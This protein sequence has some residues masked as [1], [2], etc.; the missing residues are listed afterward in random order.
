MRLR[1][2]AWAR[3]VDEVRPKPS[4]DHRITAVPRASRA[5]LR[6]AWNAT[7]GSSAHACTP[8]SPS[9]RSGSSSS[10]AKAGRGASAA[11]RRSVS[12]NRRS[13]IEGPKPAVMVSRAG[14]SPTASP[15]SARGRRGVAGDAVDARTGR[16]LVMS[17]RRDCPLRRSSSMSARR[18]VVR[19]KARKRA[20]PGRASTMPAWWAPSNGKVA[21]PVAAT[22]TVPAPS[23]PRRRLVP[24]EPAEGRRTG[25][26]GRR[27]R[28]R[29]R[30]I[31]GR[32][33]GSGPS[34]VSVIGSGSPSPGDEL[35][36]DLR[37]RLGQ[38]VHRLGQGLDL[39]GG[40]VRPG[41]PSP[42]AVHVKRA[43]W[44]SA[45]RPKIE[46]AS[47]ASHVPEGR[48]QQLEGLPGAVEVGL[49]V[50]QVEVRV[51]LLLPGDLRR[52]DLVEQLG[53]PIR[54]AGRLVGLGRD[55][56]LELQ[57]SACSFVAIGAMPVR[58]PFPQSA[59]SSRWK[60]VKSAARRA[61]SM[62]SS[63]SGSRSPKLSAT[64]SIRS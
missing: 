13:N 17:R 32:A 52:G 4:C 60:P 53:R 25:D 33:D 64:G 62:R 61:S 46:V 3:L 19:S 56:A 31:E 38:R 54:Q 22:S 6:I 16:P 34:R 23:G 20:D 37:Q 18:V 55:K 26:R 44:T 35:G 12:P 58:S 40:R 10:P 30:L 42:A 29:R 28:K 8:T 11:G 2:L 14:R 27:L 48:F 24:D 15:V 51:A 41:R 49:E 43:S 63:I 1:G 9:D 7:C 36:R 45:N 57:T 47:A 50:P 59:C 5:K 39:G 21:G